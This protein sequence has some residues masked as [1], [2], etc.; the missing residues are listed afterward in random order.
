[1]GRYRVVPWRWDQTVGQGLQ[2]LV[3][4]WAWAWAVSGAWSRAW[5]RGALGGQVPGVH[6]DARPAGGGA[7]VA[8][9]EEDAVHHVFHLCSG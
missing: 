7:A 8:E 5:R 4:A 1:M 9:Q 3:W 6:Q 2:V